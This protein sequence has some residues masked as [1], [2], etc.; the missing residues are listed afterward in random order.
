M[1][2][3][4]GVQVAVVVQTITRGQI[5]E[6]VVWPF[7]MFRSRPKIYPDLGPRGMF[8]KL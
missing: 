3:L 4:L 1:F 6:K 2:A 5:V 8:A 7:L